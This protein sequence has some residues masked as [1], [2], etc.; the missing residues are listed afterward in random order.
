TAIHAVTAV[1][2]SQ[3]HR[4]PAGGI[5]YWHRHWRDRR[6]GCTVAQILDH[7]SDLLRKQSAGMWPPRRHLR[8]WASLLDVGLQVFRARRGDQRNAANG[9]DKAIELLVP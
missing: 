4:K 7:R 9:G 3:E 5:T 1:A 6:L 8:P 2:V